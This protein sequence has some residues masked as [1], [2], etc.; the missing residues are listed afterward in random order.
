[1]KYRVLK[2]TTNMPSRLRNG[3]V[4]PTIWYIHTQ[5]LV[6]VG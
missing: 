2:K 1:M 6:Q 5:P 4:G 3:M